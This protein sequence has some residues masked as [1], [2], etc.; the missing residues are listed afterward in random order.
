M[1][2]FFLEKN[3][4]NFADI[5]LIFG[6]TLIGFYDDKYDISQLTKIIIL[7]LFPF[8]IY[9]FVTPHDLIQIL[10]YSFGFLLCV[11]FF[12][13]IDGINGLAVL[14]FL[15]TVFFVG[16]ISGTVIILSPILISSLIYLKI[17]M[18]GNIGI[19]GEAGSFFMGSVIFILYKYSFNEWTF[20]YGIIL[21]GPVFL[22]V[23]STSIIRG[24]FRENLFKGHKN[25]FYQKSVSFYKKHA[26]VSFG[27]A[28]VQLI[29]CIIV[30]FNISYF[31]AKVGILYLMPVEIIFFIF[32]LYL[33]Y[34]IHKNKILYHIDN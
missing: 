11:L 7:L 2:I 13:Q 18:K 19:Q 32:F 22:D 28:S 5:M 1:P 3:L 17:N 34:L 12:N 15:I 23:V 24:L 4:F 9:F 10:I 30:T 26:L 27:F 21:L 14:T 33:A 20:I 16:I 31:K 6:S 29:L 25:N 8:F